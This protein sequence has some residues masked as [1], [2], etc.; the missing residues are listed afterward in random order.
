MMVTTDKGGKWLRGSN[1]KLTPDGECQE[2]ELCAH[3][4]ESVQHYCEL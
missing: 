3:V 1:G 4:G 2:V